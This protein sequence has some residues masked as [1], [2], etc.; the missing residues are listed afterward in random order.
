MESV[1]EDGTIGIEMGEMGD[2]TEQEGWPVTKEEAEK[3]GLYFDEALEEGRFKGLNF[4]INE[5]VNS[6]E[7]IYQT[8]I[9]AKEQ[10]AQTS[11]VRWLKARTAAAQSVAEICDIR[12]D[13]YYLARNKQII[14]KEELRLT[15]DI[16]RKM[17]QIHA[18]E[19]QQERLLAR[20]DQQQRELNASE[21]YQRYKEDLR[22]QKIAEQAAE[23]ER[24]AAEKKSRPAGA[25]TGKPPG[26]KKKKK[27]GR[28]LKIMAAVNLRVEFGDDLRQFR[29]PWDYTFRDLH[30]DCCT[31]WRTPKAKFVLE[32][33]FDNVWPEDAIV[34]ANVE[35][36]VGVQDDFDE[37]PKI[38]L[39]DKTIALSMFDTETEEEKAA[40][41]AASMT[42]KV[43]IGPQLETLEEK[44]IRERSTLA[45]ELGPYLLFLIVFFGALVLKRS[46][47][48]SY[49]MH[50]ALKEYFTGETF[51]PEYKENVA[52]TFKD[53]ANSEEMYQWMNGVFYEGVF[54][55]DNGKTLTYNRPIGGLQV[56]TLRIGADSCEV[57]SIYA[58]G[59]GDKSCYAMWDSE[60]SDEKSY[61]PFKYRNDR[62]GN[63]KMKFR[64]YYN[65]P[66]VNGI[67]LTSA[68]T[69]T[70]YP[71]GG[72]QTNLPID[73]DRVKEAFA[74]LEANGF[75]DAGTRAVIIT[76]LFFNPNYN[77]FDY[78]QFLFEFDEGGLVHPSMYQKIFRMD[79]Y[80]EPN[81]L[82]RFV[83]DMAY[84]LFTFMLYKNMFVKMKLEYLRKAS[85]VPYF[86]NPYNFMDTFIAAISTVY[87]TFE[88]MN[89]FNE[90]KMNFKIT[91]TKY[92]ELGTI[93]EAYELGVQ[94]NAFCAFFVVLRTFEYLAI[95]ER[96]AHLVRTIG[97][98]AP[99]CVSFTIVFTIIFF[100]FVLMAHS[101]FGFI[102]A[103]FYS[104]P[105]SIITLMIMQLG[106]F[107]YNSLV[108]ADAS[109]APIFF[110]LYNIIIVFILLNV[111]IG[112][113]G[114]AFEAAKHVD[115]D[116]NKQLLPYAGSIFDDLAIMRTGAC[117]GIKQFIMGVPKVK[118]VNL[119]EEARLAE[120]KRLQEE[121]EEK[122]R[123]IE[124]E[125]QKLLN[126]GK[127][128][129]KGEKKD[130]K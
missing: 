31:L 82:I 107:D 83:F 74:E 52:F 38:V 112:I 66:H 115:N 60:K 119:I 92:A 2:D 5:A 62:W 88:F 97:V 10:E 1:C 55:A 71:P 108:E 16:V 69:R 86:T 102:D 70:T 99:E 58:S 13:L 42:S 89:A 93:A 21:R 46:V 104:M 56:R 94:L 120:E 6:L 101:V 25:P 44:S 50:D 22:Q 41:R 77:Y 81:W 111:F 36:K 29:V 26:K 79:T 20:L 76:M 130:K 27:G 7:S 72:F 124:E 19:E 43:F 18:L 73:G 17:D 48:Q 23:A 87:I 37:S 30:D 114:E 14:A 11:Q 34:T 53:I 51:P 59:L 95:S 63:E 8:D 4:N 61:V 80:G 15:R 118:K 110:M 85:Y 121:E 125:K 35:P 28:N 113:I 78:V 67:S 127:E 57:P 45:I 54:G 117:I 100:S 91:N 90:E 32:D 129:D 96:V 49:V 116:P 39:V 12:D 68:V 84:C 75:T 24:K 109:F 33:G 9:E 106:E 65:E 47:V 126:A 103:G 64:Y 123:L 40:K 98:A 3:K 105:Q 122:A 128:G